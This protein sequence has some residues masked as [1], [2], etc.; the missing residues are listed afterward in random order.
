MNIYTVLFYP[1]NVIHIQPDD[2]FG[3]KIQN[4]LWKQ[5]VLLPLF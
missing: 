2:G 3:A 4:L 1:A 5:K